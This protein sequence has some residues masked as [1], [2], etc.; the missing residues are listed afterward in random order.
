M[1]TSSLRWFA[2]A[3]LI[4]ACALPAVEID[5]SLGASGSGGGGSGGSAGSNGK[6]GSAGGGA[7]AGRGGTGSAGT[8]GTDGEAG[9]GF[10]DLREQACFQYCSTYL[11]ACG[12]HPANDYLNVYDCVEVCANSDWPFSTNPDDLNEP[13]SLQCRRAHAGFAQSSPDPHCFHS[14]RLPTGAFCALPAD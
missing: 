14:A 2:G 6:S 3:L 11:G 5:E 8:G 12:D 1:N 4:G 10:E 9:A 13:N 7:I